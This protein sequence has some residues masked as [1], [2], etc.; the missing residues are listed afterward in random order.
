MIQLVQTEPKQKEIPDL[1][2]LSKFNEFFPYP[3]VAALRQYYFYGHKN[4]FINVV[5]HIG[6]RIYIDLNAYRNWVNNNSTTVRG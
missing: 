1:I 5:K 6:K 3:T 2:P 4:G